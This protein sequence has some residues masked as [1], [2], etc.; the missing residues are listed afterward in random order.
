[1]SSHSFDLWPGRKAAAAFV[2]QAD[3]RLVIAEEVVA[4]VERAAE[5]VLDLV[6]GRRRFRLVD[7]EAVLA[8]EAGT[9]RRAR[10]RAHFG[11]VGVR[12]AEAPRP[13][14]L[15]A[16]GLR[17]R[18][19]QLLALALVGVLEQVDIAEERVVVEA[20]AVRSQCT[21]A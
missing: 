13:V 4:P 5:A 1:M 11:G 12:V 15:L 8:A 16:E 3:L 7:A 17:Q 21:G 19:G 9:G 20:R 10:Q 14:A 18:H 2:E 6:T